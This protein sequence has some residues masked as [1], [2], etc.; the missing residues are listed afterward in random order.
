MLLHSYSEALS[1]S[2]QNNLSTTGNKNLVQTVESDAPVV[3]DELPAA[4]FEQ[5]DNPEVDPY[6]PAGQAEMHV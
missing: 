5:L 6:F 2:K 1:E 3:V 4:Q